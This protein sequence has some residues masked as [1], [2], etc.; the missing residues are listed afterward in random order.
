[1]QQ[2]FQ[3]FLSVRSK[4]DEVKWLALDDIRDIMSLTSQKIAQKTIV[5]LMRA[6]C[7]TGMRYNGSMCVKF[8]GCKSSSFCISTAR[9]M[10]IAGSYLCRCKAGYSG[11]GNRCDKEPQRTSAYYFGLFRYFEIDIVPSRAV[12]LSSLGQRKGACFSGT[13]FLRSQNF[14]TWKTEQ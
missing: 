4:Y 7:G 5:G 14:V 6:L 11:D 13:V 10:D 8:A 12:T 2:I 3:I 1:M 9:C